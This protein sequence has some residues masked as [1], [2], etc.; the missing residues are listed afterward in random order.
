MTDFDPFLR[1]RLLVGLLLIP[2][3]AAGCFWS[4]APLTRIG[5]APYEAG[6]GTSASQTRSIGAFHA[7][8][9]AQGIQVVVEP[10]SNNAAT[11]TVD[12]NLLAHV[13]T[14]VDAGTLRIGIIGS[15][16]TRLPVRVRV[17]AG[18]PIDSISAASAASV[19]VR[20]VEATSLA[21]RAISAARVTV[22]GNADRLELHVDS[23]SAAELGELAVIDASVVIGTASSATAR[24]ENAITGSCFKASTLQLL[25]RPRTQSVTTDVTSSVRA[26]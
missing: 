6:S 24:V 3:V 20:H 23:A 8:D 16:E 1:R 26:Q 22:A 21:V 11:V 5:S 25:G 9:V 13:E 15:I 12:D 4:A 17:L 18:G 14:T 2:F 7:I 10:G 19:D